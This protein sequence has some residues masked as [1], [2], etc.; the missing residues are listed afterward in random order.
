MRCQQDPQTHLIVRLTR[1]SSFRLRPAPRRIWGVSIFLTLSYPCGSRRV[2][3]SAVA[4]A[5]SEPLG[6]PPG[7][8]RTIHQ[9]AAS[10][11][12]GCTPGPSRS[13]PS[14]KAIYASHLVGCRACVE[15]SA[16]ARHIRAA[17]HTVPSAERSVEQPVAAE[18]CTIQRSTHSQRA[19]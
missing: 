10:E 16:D 9:S 8:S 18:P 2:S 14:A 19:P 13:E 6:K 12:S 7:P 5:A 11:Q 17:V 3:C 4:E 1:T 15:P